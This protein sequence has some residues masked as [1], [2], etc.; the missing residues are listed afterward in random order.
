[1]SHTTH[2]SLRRFA[3]LTLSLACAWTMP[4]Q[5]QDGDADPNEDA[6]PMEPGLAKDAAIR[7]MAL[8][9]EMGID[10]GQIQSIHLTTDKSSAAG[11]PRLG[12]LLGV[13]DQAGVRIAGITPGSGADKAGLKSGDRLLRIRG[14]AITGGSGEQRVANARDALTGLDQ[15][16]PVK[17]TYQRD[18]KSHDIEVIPAATQAVVIARTISRNGAGAASTTVFDSQELARLKDLGPQLRGEVL[19]VAKGTSCAGGDCATPLLADIMR[20]NGLNLASLNPQL[21]RYF[22]T[23]QGALVLSQGALPNLEAGDVIQ[24]VEGKAVASPIEV[25]RAMSAKKPGDQAR[26]TVLRDRSQRQ[27]QVTVPERMQLMDF[28]SAPPAPPALPKPLVP[29]TPA[30]KPP[31]APATPATAAFL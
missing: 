16:K 22:G 14:Q 26:M 3:L 23:E 8:T 25:M 31:A 24:Q 11:K 20:W 27:L 4:A 15:G 5:A 1:M 28:I 6:A 2:A 19:R 21:G 17:I 18:G 10:P 9:S 13:D 30:V 12:V 7:V 29:A